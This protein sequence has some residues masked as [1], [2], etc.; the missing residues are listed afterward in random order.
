[1]TSCTYNPYVLPTIDFVAGETQDLSFNIFFYK[2]NKP[3][4]LEDCLATFS[5]SSYTNKSG[6]AII[7]KT[8]DMRPGET[9]TNNVLVVTLTSKDTV[10]LSGKYIY[11][12]TLQD[13]DGDVEI[14]KQGIL[15]I[16]NNI[17]RKLLR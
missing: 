2:S 13:I 8:M 11:Q 12:I 7:S 4:N 6:N 14:P 5:V 9:G 10:N 1:M 15:M 16:T 3:Y 17:D